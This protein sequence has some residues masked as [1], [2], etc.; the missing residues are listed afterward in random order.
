MNPIAILPAPVRAA[1]EIV[2]TLAVA[3]GIAYL[4]Q[5]YVVKPYRVPT[6]SMEP[7]LMPGDRVIADRLSLDFSNPSRGQI[8][9]FHPPVCQGDHNNEG[10][11]TTADPSLRTGPSSETFIKRVIGLPGETIWA[12]HGSIWIKPPAGRAYK[13]SEPYL[14]GRRTKAFPHTLLPPKCYFMM[15]DN[16]N[17]SDDSRMW[18]C[19]PRG[20]MIGIARVRYWPA[21][22]AG[23]L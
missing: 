6:G 12:R 18:G 4:A 8:V 19:E 3:A 10:A 20:W 5:A 1:V 11:C 2:L 23:L 17:R 7:T 13:L 21:S 15:G 9:V 16:R 14:Q 22:R